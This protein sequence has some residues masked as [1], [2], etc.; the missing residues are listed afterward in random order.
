MELGYTK[1]YSHFNIRGLG[2]LKE[3]IKSR[4]RV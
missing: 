4:A 3:L 1:C 2:L